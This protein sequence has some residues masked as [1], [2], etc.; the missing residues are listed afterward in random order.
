M[1]MFMLH[2]KGTI[3][4]Q[5][6]IK[7]EPVGNPDKN[8]A[9]TVLYYDDELCD[10]RSCPII[11]KKLQKHFSSESDD[12]HIQVYYDKED[13]RVTIG[14]TIFFD[15]DE[16]RSKVSEYK[17]SFEEYYK[18]TFSHNNKLIE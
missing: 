8:L 12:V 15:T 9:E 17:S 10:E 2:Y 4:E 5:P 13:N 7:V 18:K 14:M 3:K 11:Q 1:E 16:D 6:G